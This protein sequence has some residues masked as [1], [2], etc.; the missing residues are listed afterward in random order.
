MALSQP[1]FSETG[2]RTL[3]FKGAAGEAHRRRNHRAAMRFA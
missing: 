1:G 3:T 2:S